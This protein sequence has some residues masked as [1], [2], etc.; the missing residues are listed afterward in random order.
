MIVKEWF[1]KH[2][3]FLSNQ[4][5]H[6]CVHK[7]VHVH[8]FSFQLVNKLKMFCFSALFSQPSSKTKYGKSCQHAN[9]KLVGIVAYQI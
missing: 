9:P 7:G 4:H 2:G 6:A 5:L 1:S 8:F 3:V